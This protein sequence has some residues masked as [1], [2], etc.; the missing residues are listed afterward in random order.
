VYNRA[1]SL[2]SCLDSLRHLDTLGDKVEIHIWV[3]RSNESR[4]DVETVNIGWKFALEW[5]K[6]NVCVHIQKKH[7]FITGQWI[8]TWSPQNSHELALIL[9][10]DVSI[11]IHAYHWLRAAHQFYRHRTNISGYTLA[12]EGVTFFAPVDNRRPMYGPVSDVSYMYPVIGTTGFM[13]HPRSWRRFQKWYHTIRK[14]K[15]VKPYVPDIIPTGWYMQ[16]EAEGRQESM[17]EMWHI[18]YTYLRREW[19]VYPNIMTFADNAYNVQLAVNRQE[20][21]L[22]FD[23]AETKDNTYSLLIDWDDA[24][25]RFPRK[26]V[27]YSY[28]GNEVNV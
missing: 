16:F 15:T 18:Y 27:M 20:A 17:W 10:D 2:L 14:N 26:T 23:A 22:H 5:T 7:V 25:I 3:D 13:P 12:M 21:G 28:D 11:S 8:D 6:G 19:C 1:K 24:Y 4:V 9:E